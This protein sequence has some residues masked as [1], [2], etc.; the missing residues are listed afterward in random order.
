MGK[1][2]KPKT[3]NYEKI[4]KEQGAID[5]K[6]LQEQTAAN[7]PNMVTP[8]GTSTWQ[9][10]NGQWTNTV[11]LSDGEQAALD[12]QQRVQQGRSDAAEDLL[13]QATDAFG[14]PMDWDSLPERAGQMG[15]SDTYRQE[16][17]DAVWKLQQ[18]MLDQRR[19]QLETQ[20][21]NQGLARGSE[22]WENEMR[23]MRDSENRAMLSA[24]DSGRAEAGFNFGQD[25]QANQFNN[26]NRQSAIGETIQRRS[27]PLNE[28]NALL[29]GQQVNNPQFNNFSQAGRGQ[30]PDL[31]GA[32][33]MKN[34]S[35]WDRYNANMGGINNLIGAGQSAA[36]MFSDRRLKCDI[37]YTGEMQSGVPVAT[38]R[39]KGLPGVFR[40]FIA[41]D[42]L[43]VHPEAV[44]CDHD[45]F[46]KVNYGVL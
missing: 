26:A 28:L 24:I 3:P 46:Y 23:S 40:G 45:G 36:F 42:V 21:A 8:W 27:T 12:S 7:R 30:A 34:Q 1:K 13:G 32:A 18:P 14:T 44:E 31:M 15:R 4:A 37:Q 10:Q 16:A 22:A 33:N 43:E 25:L 39:Y 29:T 17:Q 19:G 38:F 6:L 2:S 5:L 35:E 41:Q 11:N 20:L 9:N